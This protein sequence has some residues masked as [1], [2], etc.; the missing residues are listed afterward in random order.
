[1]GNCLLKYVEDYKNKLIIKSISLEVRVSNNTAIKL[2]EENGYKISGIRKNY[3][4]DNGEDAYI[5]VKQ[6]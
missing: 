3:Y 5:M 6:I 4:E 1:M 2:Y